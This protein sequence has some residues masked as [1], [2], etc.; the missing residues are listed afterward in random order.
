MTRAECQLQRQL[1]SDAFPSTG[2]VPLEVASS[3]RMLTQ[4][5]Q[6]EGLRR[7]MKVTGHTSL[8]HSN[9][10]SGCWN[11]THLLTVCHLPGSKLSILPKLS[12]LTLL[13]SRLFCSQHANMLPLRQPLSFYE[14]PGLLHS[15]PEGPGIKRQGVGGGRREYM[16][17]SLIF[18][19]CSNLCSASYFF[20]LA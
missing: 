5:A 1:H 18:N 7:V 12:H 9:K 19:L 2:S 20:P 13:L 4:G 16:I 11:P 10:G 8:W 14:S 6:G 3:V 15:T 17:T